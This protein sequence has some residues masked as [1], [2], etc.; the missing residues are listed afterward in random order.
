MKALLT[1]TII[2]IQRPHLWLLSLISAICL[3]LLLLWS[4]YEYGRN[5]AGF[6]SA[7]ADAYIDQ[8]QG[9]LDEAQAEILENSRQATMLKRNSRIDD[10]ASVQLKETLAQAQNE[11]LELKKE[12]SFYKS[13][14]APEQGNRSVA[15]QTIQLKQNEAGAYDYK[16]MI[17]QR[18]RNDRFARGI[19]EVSIDG[20]NNRQ[21]MTLKLAEVSNA[22][23]KPMKFGF[24]Y[25]QKFEGVMN[26]PA[27]F[28]PDSLRVKVKPSTGK[29]KSIDELFAWS[30]LTAGGA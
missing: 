24:K 11:T 30:D 19:I 12:L 22:T 8:L 18:G 20:T 10:D 25:F 28:Q 9:Q 21:P 17:S 13:I 15:I 5:I 26:L 27:S 4:S 7:D 3:I 14:V 1:R 2:T 29:I 23:K 6:D 16:I